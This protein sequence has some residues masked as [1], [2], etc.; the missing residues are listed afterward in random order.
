MDRFEDQFFTVTDASQ[1]LK[2]HP[3]SAVTAPQLI[4][5]ACRAADGCI[6]DGYALLIKC[7]PFTVAP[8]SRRSSNDRAGHVQ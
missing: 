1:I 7:L 3:A 5:A 2:T 6:D 4:E 8:G